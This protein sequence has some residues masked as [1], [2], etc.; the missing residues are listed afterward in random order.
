MYN[1]VKRG[2]RIKIIHTINRYFDEMLTAISGWMP[3]YVTGSIDSYYYPKKRDGIFKRTLFIS[4]KMALVSTSIGEMKEEVVSALVW[5]NKAVRAFEK[6]YMNY[7]ELCKPLIEVFT[8]KNQLGYYKNLYTFEQSNNSAIIK[9]N[10]LSL[11]TMPQNLLNKLI[12]REPNCNIMEYYKL[13]TTNF[14]RVISE[15]KFIEILRIPRKEDL[16]EE[17]VLIS[18]DFNFS[19]SSIYYNLEDY[20][21]HLKNIISLLEKE[22]NYYI[23]LDEGS[24]IKNYNFYIKEDIGLMLSDFQSSKNIIR[25]IE[26]NIITAFWD[27]LG[28]TIKIYTDIE[29]R[30][31]QDILKLKEIIKILE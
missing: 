1:I 22:K 10:G 7:L 20:I 4:S 2:D 23:F 14:N 27:Y 11:L 29:Q 12:S 18:L 15:N 25:F 26:N 28:Y 19:N 13:R 16:I 17:K 5:D 6:E 24:I 21:C 31:K 8:E 3:L 30:K 9:T